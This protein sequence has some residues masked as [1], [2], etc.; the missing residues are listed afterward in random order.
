MAGKLMSDGLHIFSP[1]SHTHPIALAGNLPTGFDFWRGYD[2]AILNVCKEL[3]VLCLDGWQESVGVRAEID[4]ACKLGIPV[5][6][7]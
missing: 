5:R 3:W 1:I 6:Y 2:E 4:Y 7:I